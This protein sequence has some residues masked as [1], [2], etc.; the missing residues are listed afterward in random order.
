MKPEHE[1]WI[2]DYLAARPQTG[3]WPYLRGACTSA[4]EQMAAVF[5]ELRRQAGYANGAEHWWLVDQDFNIVDPTVMQF[6][7]PT[8][9]TLE[10]MIAETSYEPFKPGDEVRVGRCMECGG[11]IYGVVQALD[12][13]RPK[14]PKGASTNACSEECSEALCA[15][16]N[17]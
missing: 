4:T 11:P 14:L 8:S 5:P 16:Y 12:D 15:H 3:G 9:K 17:A 13:P 10:A 2:V 7:A 1:K 6:F